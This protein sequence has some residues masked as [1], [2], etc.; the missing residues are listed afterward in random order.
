M[1][2]SYPTLHGVAA[3]APGREEVRSAAACTQSG[4][5]LLSAPTAAQPAG[6]SSCERFG[7]R[8]TS[9]RPLIVESRFVSSRFKKKDLES[10]QS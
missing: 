10:R 4:V 7:G 9:S 8:G 2:P 1:Y 5:G 3:V 6:G